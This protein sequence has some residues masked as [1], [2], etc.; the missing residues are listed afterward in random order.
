MNLME[1]SKKENTLLIPEIRKY[2]ADDDSNQQIIS[3]L[4]KN[5]L[6]VYLLDDVEIIEKPI[7]P[8]L[9]GIQEEYRN[10]D[11][12]EEELNE[13]LDE[14]VKT[15]KEE[16][17]KYDSAEENGFVN[18]IVFHPESYRHKEV[19]VKIVTASKKETD[20]RSIPLSNRKMDDCEPDEQIIK[21][22]EREIR[23]KQIEN[24]RQFEEVVV[25]IRETEY[26]ET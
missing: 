6:K 26:I 12:S 9:E 14:A 8:T 15:Y 17:E 4:E 3:Y 19:F 1:K 24:N 23:K 5:S 13:E 16:F 11:Y 10:Y 20:V 22:N 2:W 18:G 25:M 21:I 7:E